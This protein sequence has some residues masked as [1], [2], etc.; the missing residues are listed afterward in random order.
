MNGNDPVV[1]DSIGES[2]LGTLQGLLNGTVEVVAGAIGI[3]ITAS[4][5][6]RVVAS[7]VAAAATRSTIQKVEATYTD[8]AIPP[9]DLADMVER[10]VI[11]GTGL[12][13]IPAI[14]S[15]LPSVP[16]M[17]PGFDT[18]AEAAKS[19][20]S[21]ATLAALVTNTGEPYGVIDGLRLLNR[22]YDLPAVN[23]AGTGIEL[24]DA[25]AAQAIDM[26]TYL[27]A[28]LYSRV[29]PEFYDD[30][31][32]LRQDTLSRADAIELA[33]KQ[34][35]SND[36]AQRLY[37]QAGGIPEQFSAMLSATG[38]TIGPEEA[39]HLWWWGVQNPDDVLITDTELDQIIAH[40]R[41][42]PEFTD[43]LKKTARRFLSTYQIHQALVA[44]T[45]DV[46]T[47]IDWMVGE[48]Y[49]TAQAQ[50][51]ANVATSTT[52]TAVKTLTES[53]I[54]TD[55]EGGYY[56]QAEATTALEAIGWPAEA[57]PAVLATYDARKV[58]AM[59]NA[60]VTKLQKAFMA[61]HLS[62]PQVR[63]Q[64]ASI[65]IPE[66]AADQ[67]IQVW[68]VELAAKVETLTAVQI[69]NF[70]A[71]GIISAETGLERWEQLGYNATD[72]QYLLAYYPPP[73][74]QGG[75]TLPTS[76]TGLQ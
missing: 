44:G 64:L 47:A 60:A 40:S 6:I 9:A 37:A 10:N 53:I 76:D 12:P 59:R 71:N 58:I 4:Q 73:G 8:V 21:P 68:E 7:G 63:S 17:I 5:T 3:F 1:G 51:F 35:V 38:N 31:L 52:T 50:A 14:P 66:T 15:D 57:I 54:L 24:A 46:D 43:V 67:Y 29:N 36:V 23:D 11:P 13:N 70:V 27:R 49:S 56:T 69:G 33:L 41:I 34:V 2:I 39:V 18:I 16:V 26:P 30:V 19:G 22:N 45:V 72:A 55:Y 25:A 48:G 42:N 65:G 75:S 61:Y 74:V 32:K 20:V 62:A 28:L